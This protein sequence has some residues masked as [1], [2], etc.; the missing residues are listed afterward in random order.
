MLCSLKAVIP[1]AMILNQQ[2]EGLLASCYGFVLLQSKELHIKR[3]N[4]KIY[5]IF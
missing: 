1:T 4:E 5:F 3:L 2:N